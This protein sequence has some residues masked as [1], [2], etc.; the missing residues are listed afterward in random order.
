MKR[1]NDTY[2]SEAVGI[3]KLLQTQ[4][5]NFLPSGD[6]DLPIKLDTM[7]Y[8]QHSG[9]KLLAP[10]YHRLYDKY[11]DDTKT[12]AEINAL[13]MTAMANSI[14]IMYG[15]KWQK[16][17][18]SLVASNY[19]A[20]S[21]YDI[22]EVETPDLTTENT[23]DDS[24]YGFDTTAENG[25]PKDKRVYV[26]EVTGTNTK[27]RTGRDGKVTAQKMLEQELAVRE[28]LFYEILFSDVDSMLALKIYE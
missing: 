16:L 11:Y 6:N 2:K 7:Y 18:T 24:T 28:N 15:D 4:D 1:V 23:T 20:L 10:F 21:N 19:D 22:T 14:A 13:V 9:S 3:F 26:S 25:E 12:E 27:E 17:Y 8:Y 5:F